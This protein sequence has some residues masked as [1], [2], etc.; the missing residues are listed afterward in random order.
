MWGF[1]GIC[2]ADK[3]E[4]PVESVPAISIGE[5]GPVLGGPQG[6]PVNMEWLRR[7]LATFVWSSSR[8]LASLHQR[9]AG[10]LNNLHHARKRTTDGIRFHLIGSFVQ[11]LFERQ[12]MQRLRRFFQRAEKIGIDAA[13]RSAFGKGFFELEA[14]W[15]AMLKTLEH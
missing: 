8:S 9:A 2:L 1:Q 7:G 3:G 4:D 11:Y 14:E 6:F 10:A 5:L 13:A 15:E 12:G